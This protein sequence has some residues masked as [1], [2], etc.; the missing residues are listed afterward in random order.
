MTE[1]KEKIAISFVGLIVALVFLM[2]FPPLLLGY[3][4]I[5]ILFGGSYIEWM[6]KKEDDD[7]EE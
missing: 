3:I 2:R 6:S 5:A 4:V 7:K 1:Q